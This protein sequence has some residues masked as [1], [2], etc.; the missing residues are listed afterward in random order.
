MGMSALGLDQSAAGLHVSFRQRNQLKMLL[1]K[2]LWLWLRH[3]QLKGK[4][5]KDR[6]DRNVKP[7]DTGKDRERHTQTQTHTQRHTET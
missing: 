2:L 3:H 7:Q 5:R 6:K 1:W 4:E